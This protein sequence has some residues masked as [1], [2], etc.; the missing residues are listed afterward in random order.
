MNRSINCFK[1]IVILVTVCILV[2][3]LAGCD[4]SNPG[5]WSK[6]STPGIPIDVPGVLERT[7][8]EQRDFY[9]VG[10]FSPPLSYPGDVLIEVFSGSGCQGAPLR[11]LRSHVDPTAGVTPL[12]SIEQNYAFAR[13]DPAHTLVMV[14]DLI[15]EPGGVANPGNKVVVTRDYYAG[16][17]FGG[18]TKDFELDYTDDQGLPLKD[19]TQGDYT[20][21][22]T[23]LSGELAGR[24]N[25]VLLHFG[26]THASLGRFSPAA[27]L[28]KLEEFARVHGYRTYIDPFPGNF[29]VN[30]VG[31][32][33]DNR[34]RAINSMEVVNALP[35]NIV[36]TVSAS[37]NDLIIY[38]MKP[39]STLIQVEI[40]T[41]ALH[42][43]IDSPNT[44]YHYY[45]IGEPYLVYMDYA[46]EEKTLNGNVADV[47]RLDRLV[48]TRAET[49]DRDG[50]QDDNLHVV[51]DPTPREI[52]MD[53]SDGVQLT[54]T[55]E[56]SIFGVITPIPTTVTPGQ[57]SFQYDLDN[58][59]SQI[60]F[61]ITRDNGP[62]VE[63]G[64]IDV[65]LVRFYDPNDLGWESPSIFEFK[66][67]FEIAAGPG[68]YHVD[69]L[70]R[71]TANNPIDGTSE[72]FTVEVL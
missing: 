54:Q 34:W 19:L 30:N 44:I 2:S 47:S 35:G 60:L 25:T 12:S 63:S 55:Q 67:E 8:G 29:W 39:T 24:T 13:H 10:Y 59:I 3:G 50:A 68:M 38:N 5:V 18:A 72:T 14:P 28:A 42:D 57:Y 62:Q 70:G 15:K 45:D 65:N 33:I 26:L 6:N 20:V 53:L 1:S 16:L 43:R 21:K 46:G 58:R 41:L 22:V 4:S 69:L 52:D 32:E 66:L 31:C 27:H 7:F 36:D 64:A 11:S 61:T 9:V 40:A 49:K 51:D 17:I 71:D 23:G 37:Q 48:L 56:C